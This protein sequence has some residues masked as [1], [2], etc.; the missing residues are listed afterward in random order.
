MDLRFSLASAS[1]LGNSEWHY[2]RTWRKYRDY[3]RIIWRE[4]PDKPLEHYLWDGF[5]SIRA[6]CRNTCSII[7]IT[8]QIWAAR[9]AI[10]SSFYINDLLISILLVGRFPLINGRFLWCALFL[11]LLLRLPTYRPI[12]HVDGLQWYPASDDLQS[13]TSPPT[14][15]EMLSEVSRLLD[16][17]S[18]V[19]PITARGNQQSVSLSNRLRLEFAPCAVVYMRI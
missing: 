12:S 16:S 19:A 14:K 4:H 9:D 1:G 3:Q 10:L 5:K 8:Y 6:H 17:I 2:R 7:W 15:R 11:A 13:L 18:F